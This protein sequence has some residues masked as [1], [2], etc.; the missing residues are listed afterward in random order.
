MDGTYATKETKIWLALQSARVAKSTSVQLDGIGEELPF[1]LFGWTD[2]KL[3]AICQTGSVYTDRMLRFHGIAHTASIFRR[4]WG[5]TAYTFIA[6]GFCVLQENETLANVP[7]AK[8][9]ADGNS[10]VAECLTFMHVESDT[11]NIFT[12]PYKYALGR[13]VSYGQLHLLDERDE[14]AFHFPLRL[15]K[16]LS[17]DV[18]EPPE[19]LESYY[20]MIVGGLM[21]MGIICE[22]W[23]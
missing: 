2:D 6:E 18:A 12:L 20:E 4:G 5:A 11:I 22:W 3:A 10:A 21:E 9:F 14:N 1:T 16:Y 23:Q 19:D 13:Q 17:Q 15:Q 8:Q 7:L